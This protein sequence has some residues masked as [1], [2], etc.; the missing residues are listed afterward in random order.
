MNGFTPDWLAL[1]EP[2]DVRARSRWLVHLIAARFSRDTVVRALDV[3]TGTGANMRYMAEHLPSRQE[4]LLVDGDP[5]LLGEVPARTHSWAVARGFE[6]SSDEQELLIRGERLRCRVATR[7]LNLA[8]DTDAPEA[9][10]F[11]GHALVTASA[12]LDLVSDGWLRAVAGRCRGSGAAVLFALTYDGRM[13]CAPEE[14]EDRSVRD[15]VNAHQRMDKGFGPALGPSGC[16]AAERCFASLGYRVERAPSQWVLEREADQLQHQ[17]IEGWA[18]AAAEVAP[19][20]AS[21][22]AS[23]KARRL[24]HVA[25]GR[26]RLLVGHQ[27]L[28][29]WLPSLDDPR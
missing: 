15:L 8:T 5:A 12:L 25:A 16:A 13:T 4:W 11:E 3:A 29:A 6:I 18:G 9:N 24:A 22:I 21:A 20:L 23:W 2:A 7:R 19:D 27:D 14:P 26:S 1:R 28:A 10:I 17:L